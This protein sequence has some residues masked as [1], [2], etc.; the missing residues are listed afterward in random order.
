MEKTARVLRQGARRG[1]AD[2]GHPGR[3]GCRSGPGRGGPVVS[4]EILTRGA[5]GPAAH[6]AKAPLQNVRGAHLTSIDR[7]PSP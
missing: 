1:A 7:L 2:T 3:R 6:T 5:L 4:M